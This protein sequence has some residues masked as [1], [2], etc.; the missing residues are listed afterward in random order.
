[1]VSRFDKLARDWRA[2]RITCLSPGLSLYAHHGHSARWVG[3]PVLHIT[4]TGGTR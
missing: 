2:G 3:L 4:V 1:V